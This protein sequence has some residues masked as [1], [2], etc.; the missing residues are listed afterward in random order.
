MTDLYHIG[1]VLAGP[2]APLGD[3]GAVSGMHK[4]PV[5]GIVRITHVG[6]DIDAQADLTVHGGPEKAIHHYP[7]D[8]YATWRHEL[9]PRALLDQ[10][11]AF[12]EN[13]STLGLTETDVAIGDVF[14]IGTAV[15]QVSQGRQPCWKLNVRFDTKDMA[16]RVQQSGRSGWYYRVLEEGEV[17][18]GACLERIERV[19]PAW[20]VRRIWQTLYVDRFDPDALAAL[21][22]LPT[23][24][25]NVRRQARRRLASRGAGES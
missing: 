11:G 15:L 16:L 25:E 12:G 10:P 21:A 7:F 20:S 3:G 2:V 19:T 18:P 5:H 13:L 6:I 24:A 23:V 17:A 4:R 8:H 9:P 1:H 14:R 22:A